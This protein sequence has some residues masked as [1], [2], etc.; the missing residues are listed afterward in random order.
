MAEESPIDTV[1]YRKLASQL[2]SK[3]FTKLPITKTVLK[4][5]GLVRIEPW[6]LAK[7]KSLGQEGFSERL[8]FE[9]SELLG[10]S[11]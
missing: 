8:G 7:I 9:F 3:R 2:M 10:A 4:E 6:A 1:N 11:E 5:A